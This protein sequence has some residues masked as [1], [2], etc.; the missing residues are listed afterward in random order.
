MSVPCGAH[1]F[2][3]PCIRVWGCVVLSHR[4]GR[5]APSDEIR[6]ILGEFAADYDIEAIADQEAEFWAAVEA[7]E[8]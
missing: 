4:Q 1:L 2:N 8:R 6:S 5:K 7:N 3:T